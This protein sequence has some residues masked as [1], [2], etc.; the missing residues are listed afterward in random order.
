MKKKPEKSKSEDSKTPGVNPEKKVTENSAGYLKEWQDITTANDLHN[1][2]YSHFLYLC[3]TPGFEPVLKAVM[4]EATRAEIKNNTLVVTFRGMEMLT[5]HK[6]AKKENTRYPKSFN[7]VLAVHSHLS[8]RK[9]QRGI[10]EHD[11]FNEDDGWYEGLEEE[12]SELLSYGPLKNIISPMYDYS[13]LWLYHPEEKNPQGEP[14]IYYLSHEGGDIYKPQYCNIGSLFLKRFV[15]SLGI[16][17]KIP[18]IKNTVGEAVDY[19]NWWEHLDDGWKVILADSEESI[20]SADDAQR[21]NKITSIYISDD[22]PVTSLAPLLLM[23]KLEYLN[24]EAKG[25]TD[26]SALQHLK[27]I[28]TLELTG[29]QL[30]D[31]APLKSLSRIETLNLHATAIEDISFLTSFGKLERLD[32]GNTAVKDIS[33]LKN[34]SKLTNLNLLNTKVSDISVLANLKKLRSLNISHTLVNDL[35]PLDK[36]TQINYLDCRGL[37]ITFR[38]VLEFIQPKTK[39]IDEFMGLV[40][41]NSDYNSTYENELLIKAVEDIDFPVKDVLDALLIR[42]NNTL[43]SIIKGKDGKELAPRLIRAYMRVLKNTKLPPVLH[44]NLACN[45]LVPLVNGDLDDTTVKEFLTHFVPENIKHPVLAFNLACYHAKINNKP[46]LLK[47]TALAVENGHER[48]R[49]KADKDFA[50]YLNDKDFQALINKSSYTADPETKPMEWYKKLPQEVKEGIFWE[51]PQTAEDV[52]DVIQGPDFQIYSQ[53]DKNLDYLMGLKHLKQLRLVEC[54]ASNLDA[55]ATLT[56]LEVFECEKDQYLGGTQFTDISPLAGLVKLTG[57]KLS[58]HQIKDISPLA[59]L[60]QLKHLDL[61]NNPI[62]SLEPLREMHNLKSL[63]IS[64]CG[65]ADTMVLK[66]LVKLDQFNLN[67]NNKCK[68]ISLEGLAGMK[69]LSYLWIQDLIPAQGDT[70]SLEPLA[71]LKKLRNLFLGKTPFESLKPLYALK[72]LE[73]L[74]VDKKMLTDEVRKDFLKN[75][76]QCSLD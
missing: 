31:F 26:I 30:R 16:D 28:N 5:A 74:S 24:C 75:M 45:T 43:I 14:V 44:E 68:V 58:G 36:C 9:A 66:N 37:K 64:P 12:G 67:M 1:A 57:I 62:E 3:D 4:E 71:K 39:N 51:E 23:P 56:G 29:R 55:V 76:P 8:L 65:T 22:S 20:E 54:K 70:I 49:F 59:G 32:L 63:T 38:D 73:W 47:Y 35:K 13:D 19:S 42:V 7:A 2:L 61:W 50:A 11:I 17:I 10:G 34:L 48:A 40:D 21:V 60:I 18:E 25:I 46:G 41:V 69:D 33:V 27:K 72:S 52:L 53:G 6:P 15:S